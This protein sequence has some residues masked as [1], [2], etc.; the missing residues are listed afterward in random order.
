MAESE[1]V[2]EISEGS[3]VLAYA[4]AFVAS[5]RSPNTQRAYKGAL[6][7][8]LNW[9]GQKGSELDT[10][11]LSANRLT[12]DKF[13]LWLSNQPGRAPRMKRRAKVSP[14]LVSSGTMPRMDGTQHTLAYSTV[15][16]AIAVCISFYDYLLQDDVTDRNPFAALRPMLAGAEH[17]QKRPTRA[18]SV[19]QVKKM[20]AALREDTT[21]QG[22]RNLAVILLMLYTGQRRTSIASVLMGDV[23]FE[24]GDALV[25]FRR[26]KNKRDVTCVLSREAVP[27]L[28]RWYEERKREGAA[29]GDPFWRSF[30]ADGTAEFTGESVRRVWEAALRAAKIAGPYSPHSSR[31][32]MATVQYSRGMSKEDI[33]EAGGWSTIQMVERYIDREV[34]TRP[35]A[36][37][38]V[39]YR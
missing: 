37:K 29:E 35:H 23:R 11:I 9:L 22:V 10:A 1:R 31:A 20:I 39:S 8:Y 30:H 25:T 16:Q 3:R 28:L 32:T 7:R 33:M 18:L 27:A 15:C 26:T 38:K 4:N 19:E 36:S 12:A 13:V 21:A 14:P 24:Y 2:P 5:Q 34:S 17:G 6:Q